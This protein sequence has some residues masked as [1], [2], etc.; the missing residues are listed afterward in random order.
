MSPLERFTPWKDAASQLL[1]PHKITDKEF[2][3][4]GNPKVS[5][6]KLE[7]FDGENMICVYAADG[8][9]LLQALDLK[10][11]LNWIVSQNLVLVALN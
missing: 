10:K 9:I 2:I 1:E 4:L 5:Y 11:A 8:H 3:N 6:M 7:N